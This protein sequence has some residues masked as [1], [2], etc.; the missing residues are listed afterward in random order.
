[1]NN[2]SHLKN[3]CVTVDITP[4]RGE[5]TGIGNYIHYT[6]KFLLLNYK[7]LIINGISFGVHKFQNDSYEIVH[8]L[9][10]H[11]H[12]PVPVRILYN[13]WNICRYPN[14]GTLLK[15]NSIL[16]FTNYYLPPIYHNKTVLSIYDLSFLTCP[17]WVSPQIIN[18]FKPTIFPSAQRA[19]HIITCSEKS[20][21]DIE[22][23]LNIPSEKIS[24]SYPGYDDTIFHPLDKEKAQL[25]IEKHYQI[26]SPFILFVGTIEERKNVSGLLNIYEKVQNNIPHRLVLIGKKGFH[27][28]EI[29]SKI[30]QM[31]CSDKIIYLNYINNHSELKWFYSSADMFIYPSFDEGFGIPPLEAMACGCPV[32]VSNQGALPEVVGHKGITIHPQ[33]IDNFAEAITT[34]LSDKNK[35]NNMITNSIL[36][37]KNFSWSKSAKSHYEVYKKLD[38]I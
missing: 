11:I 12:I 9:E 8:K 31:K 34:L 15:N 10:K 3:I 28:N 16:H 27:A 38:E 5:K 24:V 36:Q 30:Q 13:W 17:Q 2:T 20:K 26:K 18:L 6:L 22:T 7:D 14:I 29:L 32:I 35:Y 23:L 21:K 33:D 37:A 4:L 25:Y 1:M 19:T